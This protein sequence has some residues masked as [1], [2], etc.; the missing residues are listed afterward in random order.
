MLK[1]TAKTKK[2]EQSSSKPDKPIARG[3]HRMK[4]SHRLF[5]PDNDYDHD[6]VTAQMKQ[7]FVTGTGFCGP[8]EGAIH[9]P[10]EIVGKTPKEI[11]QKVR[12]AHKAVLLRSLA[13]Q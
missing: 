6:L 13:N 10:L 8:N 3:G 2:K 12:N 1:Q 9:D 11:A 4:G 7:K 5:L